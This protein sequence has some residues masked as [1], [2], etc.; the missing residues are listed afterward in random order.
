MSGTS[1]LLV[2][3]GIVHPPLLGRFWLR[4]GL[5]A[6]LGYRFHRVASLEALP[7]LSLDVFRGMVLYYHHKDETLPPT[8]LKSLEAFVHQGG[9]LLAIHSAS[10]SFKQEERY[11]AILGGRFQE[12]GPIEPIQVQ[13]ATLPD[14]IFRGIPAFSIE[15]ELYRHDYDAANSIHFFVTV[16]EEREPVVWTRHYGQGRVCYC[17]AGHCASTMRHPHV[18]EILQRGLAWVCRK[19]STP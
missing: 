14:E 12:H 10:A 18:R 2:S 1:V 8:A 19:R 5:K 6:M 4:R 7:A 3:D 16:G 11:F 17:A 13:P 15:D 9:G